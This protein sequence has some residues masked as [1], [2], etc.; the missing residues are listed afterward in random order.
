MAYFNR[1]ITIA[2]LVLGTAFYAVMEILR[3]E[4]RKI[5][6]I[7]SVTVMVSRTRDTGF[8][9]GP[10]TL[11]IG[12]L[13]ALLLYPPK[14]AA[15]AVYALAFGDGLSSLTGKLF[16]R[17]RPAFLFGKSIEGSLTCFAATFL[18]GFLVSR[19]LFVSTV[20]AVIA[21]ITE[22]LPLK[23]YDNLAIPL[24]TGLAVFCLM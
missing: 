2:L 19:N 6:V 8:V 1:P 5:P 17:F 15:I 24:L 9:M 22:A 14:A 4:G 12:A 10:V 20:A 13:L 3:L 18:A 11:G 16:G 23:D 21:T 7:S